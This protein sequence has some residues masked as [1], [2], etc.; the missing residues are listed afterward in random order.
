MVRLLLSVWLLVSPLSLL[1][2]A[3]NDAGDDDASC[4]YYLA[5]STIP[6]AGRG[7]YAGVGVR[8]G[9]VVDV[10]PTLPIHHSYVSQMQ[11]LNYVYGT[12][13]EA[14]SM[15]IFGQANIYNHRE[16]PEVAVRHEWHDS[17]VV[18]PAAPVT[19]SFSDFTNVKH[20][21][22]KTLTAGSEI[23]TTYGDGWFAT[24]KNAEEQ[25]VCK[26]GDEACNGSALEQV[27]TPV[28]GRLSMEELQESGHCLTDVRIDES[29]LPF[30]GK[31]L[32]ATRDFKCGSVVTISPVNTLPRSVVE[33]ATHRDNCLLVNYC[34]S[35]PSSEMMLFPFGNAAMINHNSTAAANVLPVWYDWRSKA[36]TRLG[37]QI[38]RFDAS[39]DIDDLQGLFDSPFAQFDL[40]F[41]AQRDIAKGEELTMDYGITWADQWLH[42][43]RG[44]NEYLRDPEE[45]SRPLLHRNVEAP[46]GLFPDS[47]LDTAVDADESSV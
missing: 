46:A 15:V 32:F 30:A 19:R 9:D 16:D 22:K 43:A 3:A 23:F 8:D 39:G 5:P 10:A 28:A 34:I 25:P 2:T 26:L 45:N 20:H 17:D 4:A 11:L 18:D 14:Y 33:E 27:K 24:H 42:Y 36:T 37:N 47:W 13:D 38:A 6:R 7:I 29:L 44:V 40:A 35:V 1:V 31:G 12:E 21:F 41:V